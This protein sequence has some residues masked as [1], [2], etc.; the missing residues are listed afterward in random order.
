MILETGQMKSFERSKLEKSKYS[1]IPGFVT[2]G[3]S[4]LSKK[5]R[6]S[7]LFPGIIQNESSMVSM[8]CHGDFLDFWG[9]L[10]VQFR[11][12]SKMMDLESSI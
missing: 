1:A 3:P 11:T 8:K 5:S 6:I 2:G 9:S 7:D 4:D 12:E 10:R